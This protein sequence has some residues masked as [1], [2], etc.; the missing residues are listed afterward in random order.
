MGGVPVGLWVRG[1]VRLDAIARSVAV[2]GSR[3]ATTYGEDVA[4]EIASAAGRTAGS[5]SGG[6]SDRHRRAPRRLAAGG[7]TVAVLACGADRAYPHAH[8]EIIEH[9]AEHGAVVSE[10]PPGTRP[11]RPGS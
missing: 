11:S 7:T 9:I 4:A 1:P 8:R 10:S 5:R 2:V 3:S 6:R